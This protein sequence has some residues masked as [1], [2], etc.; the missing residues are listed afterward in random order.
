MRWWIAK[1]VKVV[2]PVKSLGIVEWKKEM[3]DQNGED[4]DEGDGNGHGNQVGT[5]ED[6]EAE[7]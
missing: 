2:G 3:E 4:I 6:E 5:D 1:L 7:G